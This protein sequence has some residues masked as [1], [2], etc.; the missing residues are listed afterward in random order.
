MFSKKSNLL[1]II[2]SMILFLVF[3]LLT[4]NLKNILNIIIYKQKVKNFEY[5]FM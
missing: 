3:I 5:E 2:I 4:I 1:S